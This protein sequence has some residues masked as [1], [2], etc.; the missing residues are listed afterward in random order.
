MSKQRVRSPSVEIVSYKP[1]TLPTRPDNAPSTSASAQARTNG[2]KRK[3]TDDIPKAKRAKTT[4]AE[5][6]KDPAQR[7][8]WINLCKPEMYAA[9]LFLPFF[10][11]HRLQ[12]I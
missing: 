4:A 2:K 9:L 12:Q 1:S 10:P 6:P 3:S 7:W 5:V 11:T 8:K